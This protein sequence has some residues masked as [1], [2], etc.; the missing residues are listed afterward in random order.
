M[1]SQHRQF[2]DCVV[3]L[4]GAFSYLNGFHSKKRVIIVEQK[5]TNNNVGF[6]VINAKRIAKATPAQKDKQKSQLNIFA[7][8]SL[9][10]TCTHSI[11]CHLRNKV[12]PNAAT[13]AITTV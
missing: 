4:N 7:K 13:K 12:K 10:W 5:G 1:K 9:P 6:P 2:V 11:T 8:N 3:Y